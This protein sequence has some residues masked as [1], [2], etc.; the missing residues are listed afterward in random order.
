[1]GD[2]GYSLFHIKEDGKSLDLY[3]RSQE[4]QKDFNFPYQIGSVGDD[5]SE[6]FDASHTFK[7][8]DVVIAYSDGVSDNLY[9]SHFNSCIEAQL[10]DGLLQSPSEAADCLARKAYFLGKNMHYNAPFSKNAQIFAKE[11]P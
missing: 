2:S 1:M 9:T 7:H 6:G 8:G 3:F 11:N 5:P 10:V 4:M